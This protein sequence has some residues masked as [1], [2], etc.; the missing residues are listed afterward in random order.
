M[1]YH[2]VLQLLLVDGPAPAT[3]GYYQFTCRDGSCIED[4][5]RCDGRR[6]CPDGFDEVEC[7][8]NNTSSLLFTHFIIIFICRDVIENNL[9]KNTHN[10]QINKDM[11][12]Y[13]NI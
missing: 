9:E 4:S 8:M 13:Y 10:K 6:D 2:I 1:H 3:C 7:G 11:T 5:Q 12:K